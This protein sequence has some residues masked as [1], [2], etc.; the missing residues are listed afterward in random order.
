MPI[1][2]ENKHRYPKDWKDVRNRI[3]QRANWRCEHPNCRAR[4]GVTGYWRQYVGL[5]GAVVGIDRYGESAP[6]GALFKFFK[7]TADNVA[8]V[9]R[10]V[11]G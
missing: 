11:V 1:K 2:P 9:V 6:A 10:K 7:L 4:H 3:L 8:D 5:E